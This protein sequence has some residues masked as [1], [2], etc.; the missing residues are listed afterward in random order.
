MT[1]L[2][3]FCDGG[4]RGNPG[5]AAAGFVV[6]D[7]QGKVLASVGRFLG[8][9]TNNVAEYSAVVEALVW[10]KSNLQL[11]TYNLELF[12]D[13]KLVVS[14][15]KG[16]YKIKNANLRILAIEVKKLE[17]EVGDKV[18]Y[19]LIPREK[20]SAADRLVNQAL[21]RELLSK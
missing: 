15:L 5:P 10:I 4:A 13:S 3:I 2:F 11:R 8:K 6:K 21:D 9:T 14:Q 18:S 17:R 12:L 20:N 7:G 16:L 19:R 1:G